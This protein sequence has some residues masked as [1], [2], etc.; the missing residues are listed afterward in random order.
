MDLEKLISLFVHSPTLQLL[1]AKNAAFVVHFLYQQ[2]RAEQRILIPH[3]ALR[4]E[5]IAYQ[6]WLQEHYPERLVGPP[7]TYLNEWCNESSRILLRRFESGPDSLVYQLT[8][9][10]E[11]VLRFVEENLQ[12]EA[13]F[14]GTESRIR[15]IVET[16]QE[17]AVNASDDPERHIAELERERE[18]I[19]A[20]IREIRETGDVRTF[21]DTQ[22]R[23]RFF[24]VVDVLGRVLSDFRQVEETFREITREVQQRDAAGAQRKGDLLGFALDAEDELRESDQGVSFFGFV[25]EILVPAR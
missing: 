15:H 8:A 3:D 2:F 6:D 18:R 17:I 10:T 1:R 9:S 7:D 5:L 11:T 13:R 25:D 12:R 23:E 14:V 16:L 20:R 22:I 19:D 24:Y 21:H 4:T